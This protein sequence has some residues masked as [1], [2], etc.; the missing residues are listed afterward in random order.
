M[1]NSTLT[2]CLRN[3]SGLISYFTQAHVKAAEF[4]YIKPTD[5][6]EIDRGVIIVS[7]HSHKTLQK[8]VDDDIAEQSA[9]NLRVIWFN[10][11]P[12]N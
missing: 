2:R 7:T 6:E 3:S 4:K 8:I 5:A 10:N 11:T 12:R 1:L 9:I